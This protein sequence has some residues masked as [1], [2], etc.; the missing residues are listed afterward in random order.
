[1]YCKQAVITK[2]TPNHTPQKIERHVFKN[3]KYQVCFL[4]VNQVYSSAAKNELYFKF[5]NTPTGL[6]TCITLV[7][8]Y[9]QDCKYRAL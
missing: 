5:S 8:A 2:E 9:L 1:M 6:L 4:I 3:W 7:I